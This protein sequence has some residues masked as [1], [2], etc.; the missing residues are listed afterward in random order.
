MTTRSFTV[1]YSPETGLLLN[2]LSPAGLP[3]A[4]VPVRVL[5]K[6]DNTFY[7]WGFVDSGENAPAWAEPELKHTFFGSVR[8]SPA[9]RH[10]V[11]EIT[12]P[13]G[14]EGYRI[15]G[16]G[17]RAAVTLEIVLRDGELCTSLSL[18]NPQQL[19]GRS[20]PVCLAEL[21][22][23]EIALG[24]GAVYLSA[25]PY[26][27]GTFG[28]GDIASLPATG[29]SFAHGC[30]GLALPL[31]YLHHPQSRRGLQFEFML[32]GRP[33][34]GVYPSSTPA[35]A[36]WAISW[37]TDRLLEPGQS[38]LYG[39]EVR[40]TSFEGRPVERMRH[41][42]DSAEPRYGLVSPQTPEWVRQAN[43]IE[44]NMKP[45]NTEHPFTR[46]DDPR[47]RALLE[48]WKGMG[49]NA[50]FGV[51]CNH[52][53]LHFLSPLDYA[54]CDEVGGVEG[55]RQM[56]D[57][58]HELGFHIYLW[59]TT[60]GMD[61][62]APAVR[63]HP[64][65]FTHRRNGDLFYCWDSTAPD[66]L[67][68]APDGDPLSSG[69]RQWLKTQAGEV[70]GRGYD[71]IFIDGCI[72]RGS[73]HLRWNWPGEG[74]NGVEDQVRELAGYVRTLGKDLL[75]FVEDESLALQAACEMTMGRYTAVAPNFSG[76]YHD[77][78]MQGGPETQG[79]PVQIP[80]EMVRH[81]LL[82]RYASLLPGVVSNDI[83]EGYFCE[84][85]RPWSA[86]SLLAGMVPKT[87]SQYVNAEGT[88]VPVFGSNIEP[89]EAEKDI[90]HRL[91]GTEEFVN[92]LHFSLEEPLIRQAPLTIEGVAVDGDAAV[93]GLLRPSE[94]RAILALLQFAD[95][96]AQLSV[97]LADPVDL[98]AADRERAGRPD[99]QTWTAREIMH[100][101]VE[102]EA[103]PSAPISA[104]AVFT[105]SLAP[106]G[107]RVFEL[108][109]I[110]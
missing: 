105:V 62:N 72:P 83:V 53:G 106:Y 88:Y 30:I 32:D 31:L 85:A 68:Y 23:A 47:C 110:E 67:G 66:Y 34:A 48:R 87:H 60:V 22:F 91:R 9:I 2:W 43:M 10:E 7:V 49:Y 100:S 41:W 8:Q 81:Y 63:E 96:P 74:R 18:H 90:A 37:T 16:V 26:G 42:R 78:G 82:V 20:L 77:P 25:H 55:E 11:A 36:D 58:A 38:H 65:W 33:L 101:M 86:Q 69:W 84:H 98:P 94:K 54:P 44:F 57:W 5:L 93:V 109:L 40:I 76:A 14:E 80:P 108:K 56:L 13:D 102:K 27:G 45:G 89:T 79:K 50:I 12:G 95:R 4:G 1:E 15:T 46:L 107:F 28:F 59:I 75:T 61:R 21:R 52:E 51:A 104:D 35:H 19:G 99:R 17:E 3:L 103:V 92:L 6:G 97:R 71:G 64:E 39:G 73:N 24:N 29:V 70:V